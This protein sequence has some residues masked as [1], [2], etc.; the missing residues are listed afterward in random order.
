[1]RVAGSTSRASIT[2]FGAEEQ[3]F[4]HAAD[5]AAL[6]ARGTFLDGRIQTVLRHQPI[7][8]VGTAQAHTADPPRPALVRERVV[9]VDRLVRAMKSADPE[10]NDANADTAR[11]VDRTRDA[12][13]DPFERLL[14]QA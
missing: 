9:G 3:N 11:I 10:M 6:D 4:A 14:R 7:A 5:D 8:D 1:M 12:G 13:R 2:T